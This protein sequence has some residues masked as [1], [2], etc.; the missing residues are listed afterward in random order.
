MRV[1]SRIT[2]LLK[3][4]FVLA[5]ALFVSSGIIMVRG[6]LHIA[7]AE[8]R[9]TCQ[10]NAQKQRECFI[11]PHPQN[12]NRWIVQTY[13]RHGYIGA[14]VL[15]D[16]KYGAVDL[17]PYYN[18][19]VYSLWDNGFIIQSLSD[20]ENAKRGDMSCGAYIVVQY[21]KQ[22][23]EMS[24]CHLQNTG[25][26]TQYSVVNAGD[27][28]GY[29][30][31]TGR[32]KSGLHLHLNVY[33]LNKKYERV[34]KLTENEI[35]CL[36][37][38][39]IGVPGDVLRVTGTNVAH[40]P[41]RLPSCT[42]SSHTPTTKPPQADTPHTQQ[43]DQQTVTAPTVVKP[44]QPTTQQHDT[45]VVKLTPQTTTET[46]PATPPTQH[47]S[48]TTTP[49]ETIVIQQPPRSVAQPPTTT[50][51]PLT[52]VA[53]PTTTEAGVPSQS[54]Q[55]TPTPAPPAPE[56]FPEP[57]MTPLPP[58]DQSTFTPTADTPLVPRPSITSDTT[59]AEAD[60]KSSDISTLLIVALVANFLVVLVLLV[61]MRLS[62]NEDDSEQPQHIS[63]ILFT[64]S[65]VCIATL[66]IL[67]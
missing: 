34:D 15:Q 7:S 38:M 51:Q 57:Q 64:V 42:P 6:A 14:D 19:P 4:T 62:R 67:L 47:N 22:G 41:H 39:R 63:L 49:F 25:R 36:S 24:L 20:K 53:P 27:V 60:T 54:T 3:H 65:L 32:A 37:P 26:V 30:G 1:G 48:R 8:T 31:E 43:P 58:V 2:I 18:A 21:K 5:V 29:I 59:T 10:L 50:E 33:K 35:V 13:D 45:V 61:D 28:L 9:P 23:Y 12:A 16:S 52:T 17:Y 55:D 46:Q 56:D 66:L 40:S 44:S 11:L